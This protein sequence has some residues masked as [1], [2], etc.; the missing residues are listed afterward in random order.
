MSDSEDP[1]DIADEGGDDLFGDEDVDDAGSPADNA[2]SDRDIASDRED[3]DAG[4]RTQGNYDDGEEQDLPDLVVTDVPLYR[5][6]IPKSKDGSLHTFRVPDFLKFNPMEYK[7]KEWQ[8][9]KWELDNAASENPVPEILFRRDPKTGKLQSN[10][11]VYQWSDG[12]TTIAIGDEHFEIFSKPLAPSGNKPYNELQDVH[13]YA[14]AAHLTTNSL[15]IVGHITEQFTVKPN[16]ELQ[17]HALEKLMAELAGSK[18]NAGSEMII[19]TKE[20]PELQKK[21]AELAE[22]ERNK[23][24]RRRE[25]AAARADGNAGRYKGGALSIDGLEGRRGAGG[26]GRKRGAPGGAKKKHRRPEYDSDDE[27]PGGVR[28]ADNYDLDDGFLVGSD[29]ES[30]AVDE[31]EEEDFL[32]DEDEDDRPRVKRQRTADPDDDAEGEDDDDAPAASHRRRRRVVDDDD[33][34]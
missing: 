13:N 7:P 12:S 33:E 32:D 18:K 19:V 31:E 4:G 20:D 28:R 5:H 24:Q 15:V 3:D 26:A 21:Q 22:K 10:T 14:A 11:N 29:E 27:L 8:P 6:R 17:D 1:I 23:L 9:S 2:P 34:E 30:E 16:K 25:T